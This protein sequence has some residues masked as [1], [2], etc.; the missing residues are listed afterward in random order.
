MRARSAFTRDVGQLAA[1]EPEGIG[2]ARH[3][4]AERGAGHGQVIGRDG[5]A[6]A[7]PMQRGERML[8]QAGDDAGLDVRGRAQ[9]QGHV[10][11]SQPFDERRILGGAHA[12]RNSLDPEVQYLAHALGARDLARMGRES[13]PRLARR[14]EGDRVRWRR[15]RRLGS[16]QVEPDDGAP[17]RAGRPRQLGI[18][19]RRVRSHRCDD[20]TDQGSLAPE[21]LDRSTDARRDGLDDPLDR[22][23]TLEV[24]PGC[25][26]DLGVPDAI[27]GEVL[28]QLGRGPF[29]GG[30]SL[31][32]RDRQVD[33]A[34]GS[35]S[36]F[37][38]LV[39]SC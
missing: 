29:E 7:R 11:V 35:C 12:V 13:E 1:G 15:P 31:E 2:R 38:A 10:A 26:A 14:D 28:D 21:A 19:R 24:Q 25:P 22:Q 9:V 32:Q 37:P 8:L 39:R 18:G 3:L 16:G 4:L 20:E 30:R 6:D 27:G 34:A 17:E 23:A 36:V 33:P 5:D